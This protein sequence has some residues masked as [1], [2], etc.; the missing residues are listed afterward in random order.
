MK[1]VKILCI[2]L[3]IVLTLLFTV[4]VLAANDTGVEGFVTRLY[5]L[6]LDR[7]PDAGGFDHWVGLLKSKQKTGADVASSL[8][9]SQ[10]FTGKNI[11]NKDFLYIMYKAFFDR[12]PDSVGFSNWMGKM[13]EGYNRRYIVYNFIHSQEFLNVCNKYGIEQVPELACFRFELWPEKAGHHC[14][15]TGTETGDYHSG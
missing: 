9:F 13:Q 14:L 5:E 11:S 12:E 8:I 3:A 2:S 15:R 4:P 1:R 6:T 7:Q 10:E